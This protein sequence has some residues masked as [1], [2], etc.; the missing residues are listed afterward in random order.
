[1]RAARVKHGRYRAP[2]FK[3]WMEMIQRC[4]NPKRPK[5]K[6]YGARGI[7]VC[8]RWMTFA[9]FLGD[10]GE[11]PAGMSLDRI[12]ND[13][14]YEPSNCR[15]ATAKQQANNKRQRGPQNA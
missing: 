6:Y 11:R 1:V 14:N 15:W 5:Y 13:W 2:I 7:K 8:E 3:A 10:M 4:T 12:N 9:N